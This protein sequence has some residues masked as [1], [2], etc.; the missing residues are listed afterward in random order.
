MQTS[1]LPKKSA[2]ARGRAG[3]TVYQSRKK[4]VGRDVARMGLLMEMTVMENTCVFT[5]TLDN[6]LRSYPHYNK[7]YY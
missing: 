5:T 1:T 4:F 3:I 7:L 6:S 2:A